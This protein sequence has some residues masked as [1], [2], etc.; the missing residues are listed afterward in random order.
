MKTSVIILAILA[1]L[2]LLFI[3]HLTIS[4]K[5]FSISLPYW[6]RALG[7]VLFIIG[8]ELYCYSE[9]IA[10]YKEGLKSGMDEAIKLLDEKVKDI[11]ANSGISKE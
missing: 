1:V 3:G 6:N 9:R 11:N 2:V 8:L 7:I 4:F 5:P 10:G